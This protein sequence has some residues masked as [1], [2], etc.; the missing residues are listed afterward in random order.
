LRE[1]VPDRAEALI[2]EAIRLLDF[3]NIVY[4]FQRVFRGY[5]VQLKP[6]AQLPVQSLRRIPWMGS[7]EQDHK[8]QS[9]GNFT[10]QLDYLRWGLDRIDQPRLPLD[11]NY[12][13]TLTGRGVN[14]YVI[15]SGVNTKHSEF[16]GRAESVFVSRVL[17]NKTRDCTVSC[18]N[19]A[20][21]VL[22]E[23]NSINFEINHSTTGPRDACRWNRRWHNYR[24]SET[25][26]YQIYACD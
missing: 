15:D 13:Y 9:A 7:I 6:G 22:S 17:K 21:F 23:I 3:G 5:T 14:V 24:S 26:Q 25:S 2:R 8:V 10:Q 11:Y 19:H 16:G 18:H 12:T 1:D 4:T 20:Q